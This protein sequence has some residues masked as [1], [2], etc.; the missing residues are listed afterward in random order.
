MAFFA[1]LSAGKEAELQAQAQAEAEER[2]A[3]I[4]GRK[5]EA[6]TPP[7]APVEIPEP[8]VE[9]PPVIVPA[10]PEWLIEP[11]VELA[12]EAVVE[13]ALVPE[14]PTEWATWAEAKAAEEAMPV[15]EPEAVEGLVAGWPAPKVAPPAAVE[16]APVVE[17]L[18][19]AAEDVLGI[20][21]HLPKPR[22]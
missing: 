21:I 1:K 20:A 13:A 18:V 10:M 2:M 6:V 11:E 7:P 4:M 17:A 3:S 9:A 22:K 8:K 16:E 15:V 19:E 14:A 12:P 5:P